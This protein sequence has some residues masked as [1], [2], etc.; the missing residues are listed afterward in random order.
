[1]TRARDALYLAGEVDKDGIL[2]APKRSLASLLPL[3]LKQAFTR[4]SL[5][6]AA[7]VYWEAAGHQFA[8]RVCSPPPEGAPRATAEPAVVVNTPVD[9]QPL[10][11][12]GP[13]VR[14]A[15]MIE[16]EFDLTV[17]AM[18][19]SAAEGRL[20]RDRSLDR[21]AG[22]LV[23]RLFQ[24]KWEGPPGVDDVAKLLADLTRP[25]ELV[26]VPD[27]ARLFEDVARAFLRLAWRSDVRGWL[28]E[29]QAY[30]EVPFSFIPPGEPRV[31]VR[32]SIDCLVVHQDGSIRVL[33]FKTGAP[34]P[35]HARQLDLYMGAV[36]HA[37]P[38]A[39]VTGELVYPERM[40]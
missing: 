1:V 23:H 5:T 15:T 40:D 34:R 18:Q 24:L 16:P 10:R 13:I 31:L 28:A 4:A 37:F 14:T 30:F 17:P 3:S 35:E 22:T 36:R 12:E 7:E 26:D 38:G 8:A 11:G 6:E 25:E 32:G 33:E 39:A 27:R 19:D 20:K 29:G 21:V 2:R 9:R